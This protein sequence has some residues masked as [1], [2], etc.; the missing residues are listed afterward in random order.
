[1]ADDFLPIGGGSLAGPLYLY[2]D[3]VEALEPVT[4]RQLL[5]GADPEDDEEL[6][7]VKEGVAPTVT[8]SIRGAIRSAVVVWTALSGVHGN[9]YYEVE[10]DTSIN[11][12]SSNKQSG[13]TNG[14]IMGFDD[15]SPGAVYYCRLRARNAA[16]EL[17]GWSSTTNTTLGKAGG[18]D[19]E[20]NS[21]LASHGVFG[22]AAIV[23]ADIAD[24]SAGKITAGTI[25]SQRITLTGTGQLKAGE[26]LLGQVSSADAWQGLRILAGPTN[27]SNAFVVDPLGRVLFRLNR[28]GS[29]SL[30]FNSDVGVLKVTGDIEASNISGGSVNGTYIKSADS[31]YRFVELGPAVGSGQRIGWQYD[32]GYSALS[33]RMDGLLC[34]PQTDTGT[35]GELYV[36]GNFAV[37]GTKN[38][39]IVPDPAG[40]PTRGLNFAATESNTPGIIEVDCGPI[41]VGPSRELTLSDADL[42]DAFLADYVKIGKHP[43]V[44]VY[45]AGPREDAAP[46]QPYGWAV[47]DENSPKIEVRGPAGD[48]YLELRFT[49]S[50]AGV[51]GWTHETVV[52]NGEAA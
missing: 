28:G 12:N 11:F 31:V 9:G 30:E 33:S 49:R 45:S 47:W 4:L 43:R 19:I 37:Q 21:I 26:V 18:V 41:T 5:H 51:Q 40:A 6:E 2:S 14:L 52:D 16:G 42:P 3:A 15:M 7:P 25:E 44:R 22:T 48:Y 38:A 36:A 35:T 39:R 13:R 32:S 24:L 23:D 50:D 46:H 20:A 34:A 29:H 10:V 8:L 27:F 17:S 1:M